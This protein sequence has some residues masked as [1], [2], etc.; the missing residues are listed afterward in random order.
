M[1]DES[2]IIDIIIIAVLIISGWFFAIYASQTSIKLDSKILEIESM[3]G[4]KVI[5]KS[6]TLLIVD[7]SLIHSSYTLEDG[8]EISFELIK[9]LDTIKPK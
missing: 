9:K 8:K 4:E 2:G 6:D 5:F 1:K 7:Y 3:I